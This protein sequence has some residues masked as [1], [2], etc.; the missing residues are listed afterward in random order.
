MNDTIKILT[1]LLNN[2]ADPDTRDA[3][4]EAI[5][6][7][8]RRDH[9]SNL[10]KLKAEID[11]LDKFDFTK[12]HSDIQKLCEKYQI[13]HEML[14][15]LPCDLN[16]FLTKLSDGNVFVK[17][18]HTAFLIDNKKLNYPI[19]VYE[20]D[21]MGY[22]AKHAYAFTTLTDSDQEVQIWV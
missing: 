20:D 4:S 14:E 18:D 2:S 9:C 7:I 3:L 21:G 19:H 5:Q 12:Y 6:A 1:Y 16:S 13:P 11:A 17:G 22:G 10:K 15:Y 8:K